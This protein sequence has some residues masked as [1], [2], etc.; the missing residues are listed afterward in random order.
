MVPG[1]SIGSKQ[2]PAAGQVIHRVLV[3]RR[4]RRPATSRAPA[5]RPS[6]DSFARERGVSVLRSLAVVRPVQ[7]R[8]GCVL[9]RRLG[10]AAGKEQ[11]QETCRS[12][13][14]ERQGAHG[15][16]L[17]TSR[18]SARRP[19]FAVHGAAGR[20]LRPASPRPIL[21]A[22]L[23][24]V[25]PAFVAGCEAVLPVAKKCK[26]HASGDPGRE[27]ALGWDHRVGGTWSL[28]ELDRDPRTFAP[29]PSRLEHPKVPGVAATVGDGHHHRLETRAHG[30]HREVDLRVA[31]VRKMSHRFGAALDRVPA[32][33]QTEI[34]AGESTSIA[35]LSSGIAGE[36]RSS[37]GGAPRRELRSALRQPRGGTGRTVPRSAGPRSFTAGHG[38]RPQPARTQRA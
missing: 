4:Q 19:W 1:R 16:L 18:I 36:P 29:G 28:V 37:R 22:L 27:E 6:R 32:W 23:G 24:S 20:S 33:T 34:I 2:D 7:R 14:D 38:S 10:R 21:P 3:A 13:E 17:R 9:R 25:V 31:P 5:Q 26:P 35:A 11:K 15:D 12:G 30:R 8:D